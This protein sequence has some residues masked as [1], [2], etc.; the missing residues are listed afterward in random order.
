MKAFDLDSTG[1]Y[2]RITDGTS[3]TVLDA[4]AI[5]A[6]SEDQYRELLWSVGGYVLSTV[7]L[8]GGFS[9]PCP[10]F[11]QKED[12]DSER[13]G[14]VDQPGF[15]PVEPPG[16]KYRHAELLQKI[17]QFFDTYGDDSDESDEAADARLQIMN[18]LAER[19]GVRGP[20]GEKL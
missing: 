18:L 2:V 15:G 16:K 10:P 3:V 12:P 7:M 20:Q 19:F 11:P 17:H 13:D 5:H 14:A 9:R 6:L 8:A 1:K 4:A